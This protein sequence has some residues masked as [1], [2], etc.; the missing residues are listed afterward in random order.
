MSALWLVFCGI[1]ALL[2]RLGMAVH[3]AGMVRSKNSSSTF[4]RTI[5]DLCLTILAF[6]AVGNAILFSESKILDP[7]LIFSARSAFFSICATLIASGI[8]TGVAS[9]RSR[10]FPLCATSILIGALLVPIVGRWRGT[11]LHHLGYIDGGG[12]SVLHLTGGLCAAVAAILIGPRNGKYNRDGSS[13]GIPGHS[14]P[15][16]SIG[17]LLMFIGWAPTVLGMSSIASEEDVLIRTSNVLLAAAAGGAAS[18]LLCYSR[19]GKPDVHLMIVGFLGALVG[20]SALPGTTNHWAVF[21]GGIAGIIVPLAAI[22]I[23]LTW[24]IDDPTS[25]IAIHA[26]SAI[27]GIIAAGALAGGTFVGRMKQLG[28]QLLGLAA[29]AALA[30]ILPAALFLFL[31]AT[32]GLR[33]KEADEF[34]GLDLAEHDIGA[35]PDFQQTTIKSYHLREA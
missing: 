6:W 5:T 13:N 3:A 1:G 25:G 32:V 18:L 35:Y 27:W 2:L 12:A 17:A 23:D 22:H 31:K 9:E 10:F 14:V 26:V 30:I 21:I 33:A 11:W 28:I 16:A 8:V 29:I 19:Y 4:I 24:K 7:H 20:I 15:L 34:D